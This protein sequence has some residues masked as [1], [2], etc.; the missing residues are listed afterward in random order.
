MLRRHHHQQ[1]FPENGFGHEVRVVDR[2]RQQAEVGA[3]GPQLPDQT[4]RRAGGE[5]DLDCG[6]LAT[7][8]LQKCREHVEADRH[9]ADQAQRAAQRL[10][11]LED[12]RLR[13]PDFLEHPTAE[14]EQCRSGGRD[15]NLAADPKEQLL[16]QLL[17]EKKNLPADGRLRQVKLVTGG[18][19]GPGIGHGAQNLELS[20]VHAERL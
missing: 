12:A 7:E 18:R 10:P 14:R 4:W 5:L 11:A 2:Q 6:M 3:A 20:Q 13:L 8:F 19:K 17:F 1:L 9:A 15:P 16:L